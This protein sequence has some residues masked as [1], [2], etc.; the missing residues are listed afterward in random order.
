[1]FTFICMCAH[2]YIY[3]ATQFKS[4]GDSLSVI[5]RDSPHFRPPKMHN[6]EHTNTH[7][8]ANATRNDKKSVDGLELIKGARPGVN[9]SSDGGEEDDDRYR[10]PFQ[11]R[12]V[13][14]GGTRELGTVCITCTKEIFMHTRSHTSARARAYTYTHTRKHTHAHTNRHMYTNA[15]ARARNETRTHTHIQ[16]HILKHTTEHTHTDTYIH[17]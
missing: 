9:M 14:V 12:K 4:K 16:T 3:M 8:N 2:M 10:S 6:T 11:G 7:A 13:F 5:S 1:M 15:R 17:I